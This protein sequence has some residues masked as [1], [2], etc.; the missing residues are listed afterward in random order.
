M[1][2]SVCSVFF[3]VFVF[4]LFMCGIANPCVR[5]PAIKSELWNVVMFLNRSEYLVSRSMWSVGRRE[6]LEC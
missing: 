2:F 6:V 1:L 4:V 3:S 5:Y